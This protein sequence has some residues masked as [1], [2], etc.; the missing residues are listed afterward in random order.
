MART[1]KTAEKAAELKEE[2]VAKVDKA[3]E[4]LKETGAKATKT[5]KKTA[6]KAKDAT[7]T[8]AAKVKQ[9]AAK[10]AEKD[11]VVI[12]F[13]D[14]QIDVAAVIAAAKADYKAKGNKAPKAVKLYIKPEEGVAYYTVNDQGADDQ[15]VDL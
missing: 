9:T 6:S 12:E 2:A 13:G 8:A 11:A 1:T 10:A 5:V 4:A 14:K 7:K 3:A 15:K